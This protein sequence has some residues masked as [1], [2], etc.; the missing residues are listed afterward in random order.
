MAGRIVIGT[1]SWA[2]PGFV[3]EWYPEGLP[4][5]ER[6][7]WYAQRFEAVELN[8]SFYAVPARDSVARWAE[9]T[10]P[11]FSF[12]VKL[13]RLLSHHAAPPDSLPREL[14]DHLEVTPRGRVVPTDDLRRALIGSI[15]AAVQPVQD[16]GKLSSFLL[17]L[18]PAFAPRRH[19]LGELD[20]V[21]DALAP[22]RVAVELRHRAWAREDRLEATLAYLERRNAAWV[23]VDAPSG[24]QIT[25]MPPVDAVTS[26]DLA[27]LRLHGR[28]AAGYVK[29]RSVAERFAWSYADDELCQIAHRAQA[30]ALDVPEVRV[31]ANNN[32]GADAPRAAQRLRELLGQVEPQ[33]QA[34]RLAG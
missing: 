32:R 9:I 5:A 11:G 15:L 2:D 34:L 33:D 31:M 3:E 18:S 26:R 8:S 1:S 24:E 19:D 10:P 23:G 4:A 12:D 25:I 29:G 28:N 16:A 6:L 30:L 7:P 27:Y 17:Q 13:H 21:L 22:H 20:V 14:R